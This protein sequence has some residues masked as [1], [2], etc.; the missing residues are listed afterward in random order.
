MDYMI[1]TR[2]KKGK[3]FGSE[4]GP[5]RFL[6][7]PANA[8]RPLPSHAT[9][10]KKQWTDEVMAHSKG[11]ANPDDALPTGDILFFVHGY[12]NSPKVVLA[13]QRLLRKDLEAQGFDG[14]VVGFD[15]PSGSSALNYLEDRSDARS[16]ALKLVTD[17]IKRFAA[18][19][20]VG[21]NVN[22]HIL[23]HS[24]GAF[25]IREAFDDA[26]DTASIANISWT[27]S[28]MVFISADV[29]RKAMCAGDSKSSSI[30]RHCVRLTN[31]SNPYDSVLKLSNI[32][33]VGVA[34]RAGRVGLPEDAGE[35]AVDVNCGHYFQSIEER[36]EAIGSWSHSWHIGDPQFTADLLHTLRGDVDRHCIETRE[37]HPHGGLALKRP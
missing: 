15:W 31:Y 26:D 3:R 37:T 34:P 9:N 28:Q 35:K 13:R 10:L 23:A 36:E 17:G 8:T 33:R 25:V 14:I 22:L 1:S 7:V 20:S 5:T 11:G 2:N 21:C 29:S 4:P 30:Y 18:R 6:K 24:T 32:K 27:V 12:N 19:Q 16:T